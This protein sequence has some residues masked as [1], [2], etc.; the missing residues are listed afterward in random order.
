MN[1]IDEGIRFLELGKMEESL[2][3]LGK[4]IQA[5]EKPSL[6]HYYMGQ[7]NVE[8]EKFKVAEEEFKKGLFFNPINRHCLAGLYHLHMVVQLTAWIN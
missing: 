3:V 6:A 8:L 7:C 2:G 4:A 5:A 1:L